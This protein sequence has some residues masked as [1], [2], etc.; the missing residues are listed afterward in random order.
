MR[1]ARKIWRSRAS[2]RGREGRSPMTIDVSPVPLEEILA[3]RE[4]YRREMNCQIV[5]DSLPARGFGEPVPA[6]GGR[7][8]RGLRLRDG[9]SRRAEGHGPGVLRPARPPRLGA[10]DVPPARRGRAGPGGSRSRPTTSCSPSCCTTAPS[11]ITSD[12]V[13]FHDAMA[14]SL[15]VPGAVFR[16]VTEA[17][18]ERI[19]EHKVEPVGEWLVERRRRHRRDRRDRHPLQP[20]VRRHLHGGG[21]AAS[22]GAGT[23]AT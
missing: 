11:E 18:K 1:T 6:P 4:L 19:F 20:P 23:A 16:A 17:D 22:A 12:T 14:T 10:A 3:L 2:T 21:R 7:P 8:G 15:A 13:V 5:H 9:L